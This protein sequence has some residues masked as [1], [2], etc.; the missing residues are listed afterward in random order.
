MSVFLSSNV[1][2]ER[3]AM[4]SPKLPRAGALNI[5]FEYGLESRMSFLSY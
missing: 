2:F 4:P 1:E 3:A 5:A